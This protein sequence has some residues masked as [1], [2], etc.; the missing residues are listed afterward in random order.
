MNI[1]T[2]PF[3][4][5]L[6]PV[7]NGEK[8][9]AECIE[10][11]LGQTYQNW[12]YLIV[13]NCSNDRTLEIAKSYTEKD[14]R[15]RIHNNLSFYKIIPNWNQAIL[16]ISLKS[17]YCKIVHADDA[18]FPECLERMVKLAEENPTVGLVG[19]HRLNGVRVA[20]YGLPYGTSIVPGS[21]IC[22]RSFRKELEVF[23][24]PSSLLIR[25]DLIQEHR[26]FY[27]ESFYHADTEI[28][29][30]LLRQCDFGFV[31]QVLT[32]TR[33]H[34]NSE[35]VTVAERFDSN[36]LDN[37]AILKKHGPFHFKK[38]EY[39][40]IFNQRMMQHYRFLGRKYLQGKRN[41]V[42]L[43]HKRGLEK[44]GEHFSRKK[45]IVGILYEIFHMFLNLQETF[46]NIKR[47]RSKRRL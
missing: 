33:I 40:K 13:N 8:Y 24:S 22:R 15:I 21:E 46:G 25:S 47:V 29:F 31:H 2:Q 26:P 39:E 28:C 20:A 5:I 12:E 38:G 1:M 32:F 17:K 43:Y 23:G 19:S 7:Y 3:V 27:D 10:S 14:N 9:L 4:S 6:T 41:E 42:I 45:L 44:M 11:I 35:T 16:Q 37:F 30:R 36:L 18:L 34:E